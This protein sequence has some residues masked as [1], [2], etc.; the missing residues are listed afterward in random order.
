[1]R[2]T[3]VKVIILGDCYV[4]KSAF[5]WRFMHPREEFP[6]ETFTTTLGVDYFITLKEY[7]GVLYRFCLWDAAGQE[8]FR[9]IIPSYFKDAN[10]VVF[11]YDV[12][13][14]ETFANISYWRKQFIS[15]TNSAD[16]SIP[17]FFLIG[18][19]ID[20]LGRVVSG[21]TDSDEGPQMAKGI[22]A[23]FCEISA[24]TGENVQESAE[25][26]LRAAAE[27]ATKLSATTESDSIIVTE[28]KKKKCC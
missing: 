4:G 15:H 1:M 27:H 18:T 21:E 25:K 10:A 26:I 13:D 20:K 6:E 8:K 9:T 28:E 22:G 3:K 14:R 16:D 7:D 11:V 17:P 5:L 24:K 19:K 2:E 23:T 12:T